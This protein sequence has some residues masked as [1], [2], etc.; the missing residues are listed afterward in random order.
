MD[1]PYINTG[2]A[3]AP[4]EPEPLHPAI[5]PARFLNIDEQSQDAAYVEICKS[6][7]GILTQN[8]R[9]NTSAPELLHETPVQVN[10]GRTPAER[11]YFNSHR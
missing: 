3:M 6:D 1:N 8:L 10:P 4:D 11:R 5:D 7:W 2:A 9:S